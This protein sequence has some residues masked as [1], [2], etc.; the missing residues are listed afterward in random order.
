MSK[1]RNTFAKRQRETI[2]KQKADEKRDRR[3]K[4]KQQGDERPAS[5]ESNFGLSS[6][7]LAVLSVFAKYLMTPGKMLCFGSLD[8]KAL[9]MPL[10]D[11]TS[12]GL[13]VRERFQGGYAL[14]E[15]GFAAM[16]NRGRAAC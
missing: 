15:A 11:L 16:Q 5:Q 9:G 1:D 4:R 13:L 10:S 2:R 3:I 12:K 8:Q 6:A 14:T 7:E